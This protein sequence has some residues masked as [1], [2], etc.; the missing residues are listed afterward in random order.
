MSQVNK[1]MGL[2]VNPK[3]VGALF[4]ERLEKTLRVFCFYTNGNTSQFDVPAEENADNMHH[5]FSKLKMDA[6]CS[7]VIVDEVVQG[8][9]Y[10]KTEQE[11]WLYTLLSTPGNKLPPFNSDIFKLPWKTCWRSQEAEILE[12]GKLGRAMH[13]FAI[14][15]QIS[16]NDAHRLVKDSKAFTNPVSIPPK[17]PYRWLY[18]NLALVL[19]ILG[20]LIAWTTFYTFKGNTPKT[21]RA[22]VILPAASDQSTSYYLLQNRQISGPYYIKTIANMNTGGL[23]HSNTMCRA[24]NSTEWISLSKVIPVPTTQRK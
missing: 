14:R 12:L 8:R 16:E 21:D 5:F 13:C 6:T 24:E 9:I 18:L 23:L 4:T 11:H 22:V 3:F 10:I 2:E 17:Q 15:T 1:V 19:V 20:L 7:S